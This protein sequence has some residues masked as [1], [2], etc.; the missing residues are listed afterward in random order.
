MIRM[1]TL[2]LWGRGGDWP[3]RRAALRASLRELDPDLIAA[4]L[5]APAAD[6][7]IGSRR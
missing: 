1:L 7:N 5:D 2:N 6:P 3:R 4:D